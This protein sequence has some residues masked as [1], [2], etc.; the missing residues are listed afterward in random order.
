MHIC[1]HVILLDCK[2]GESG[3]VEF[4]DGFVVGNDLLGRATNR[5]QRP[6]RPQCPG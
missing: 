6:R 5:A 4:Y 3:Q 2:T 1:L